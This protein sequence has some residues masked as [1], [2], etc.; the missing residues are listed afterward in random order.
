MKTERTALLE[1]VVRAD[2]D[3]RTAIEALGAYEWD[4]DG[5]PVPLDRRALATPEKTNMCQPSPRAG[6]GSR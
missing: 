2:A 6:E 3:F 1:K 4:F 5:R